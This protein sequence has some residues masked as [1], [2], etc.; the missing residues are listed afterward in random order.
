MPTSQVSSRRLPRRIFKGC[1][2]VVAL[3]FAGVLFLFGLLWWDHT[4]ETVLP[5][6]T[7]PFAVGRTTYV[8]SD[9]TQAELMAP[10]PGTKR[11]LFAWIWYPAAPQQ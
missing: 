10:Q 5:T 3:G 2:A 8:W 4:R 11:E 1:A 7:G 6:P 9:P